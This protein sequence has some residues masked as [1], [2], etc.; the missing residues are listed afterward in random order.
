MLVTAKSDLDP[1]LPNRKPNGLF[2]CTDCIC[3][4]MA[5]SN[6]IIT[7]NYN[8][9]FDCNSK[10]VLYILICNNC[11]NFYIGKTIDFKQRIHNHKSNVKHAQNSTCQECAE[12]LRDYAKIGPFFQIY[13]FYHEKDHYLRD[14]KLIY[15]YMEATIKH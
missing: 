11:D 5:I 8:K 14:Y 13:L 6:H 3:H 2:S 9:F 10:D 4:K 15:Y 12:H 7:W 1:E